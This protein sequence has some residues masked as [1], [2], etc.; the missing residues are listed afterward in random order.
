MIK[1]SKLVDNLNYG[2]H[3]LLSNFLTTLRNMGIVYNFEYSELEEY[4]EDWHH[5]DEDGWFAD[6]YYETVGYSYKIYRR[7]PGSSELIFAEYACEE[8]S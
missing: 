1:V 8:G 3:R 7:A 4:W 6:G 5:D 2:R